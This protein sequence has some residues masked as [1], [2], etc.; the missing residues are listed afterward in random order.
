VRSRPA[1]HDQVKAALS[2]ARLTGWDGLL[3]EQRAYL[4]DFWGR[5]DVE[6]EG[7]PQIQQA[8]RFALFHVLQAAARAERRPIAAKGLTGPGYDGHAFWDTETFVLPVLML[9]MPEAAADAL[10]WR[11]S[12]LEQARQQARQLGLRGAAFPWRTIQGAECSGYWPAGTAGFHIN[13]DIAYALTH[14]LEATGDRA[15][16][17]EVGLEL[18]VETARLWR[19]L[20]Y[21][22]AASDRFR[23]DGVTGPDE[24]SA[25]ADNNVYTN[26]MAQ[27][28]LRSAAEVVRRYPDK[29]RT[30]GVDAQ[31]VDS[32]LQAAEKMFI[33][34][35]ERLA[36]TPQAET[37]T[38]HEVWDFAGTRPEQYPLLLHFPYFDLYRKQVIK[39]ADL[40]LAMQ[41]CSE[42]FTPEQKARNFAY[43]EPLTVRDSSLS[44]CTQAVLAA[45][46]GQ[47]QLAYDYL[48]EAAL[49]DL[50]DL[51]HNVRQGVH[52]ASL[53]GAWTALVAGFGGLR[54][55]HGS[56]TFAPRLPE[57]LGRLAF[58]LLFQ[59]R[60]LRIE[61]TPTE[62]TYRL[63]EGSPLSVRHHGEEILLSLEK[64]VSRPIPTL[65][66]G[67]RPNQP[68]GR[69]PVAREAQARSPR[70]M[71]HTHRASSE[72]DEQTRAA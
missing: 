51:H 61:V 25:L 57:S 34:Y 44:A 16:E 53:A 63:L 64:A 11:H 27:H 9:T 13:A 4:D 68:A 43:Y 39:Q 22:H 28:N 29:A 65:K 2:A 21:Y 45:E 18:L 1:I 26:L 40:V 8:V 49:I 70:V 3:G 54:M 58:H 48:G 60:R 35:D 42:A 55:Q 36:V 37:F 19:A 31:E 12:I 50:H 23:I 6:L 10:R 20:G 38:D 66:A 46:V 71:V 59:G 17:E 5:A 7:D 67:P 32:W 62:A 69:T 30:L 56:L 47:L 24:Y 41:L 15:F 33:P 72:M 52:M 14:Y